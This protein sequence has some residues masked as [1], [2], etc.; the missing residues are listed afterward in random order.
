MNKNDLISTVADNSGLSK[1]DASKAVES[2][3]DAIQDFF[4]V[5]FGGSALVGTGNRVINKFHVSNAVDPA[6]PGV[7]GEHVELRGY[8]GLH[9]PLCALG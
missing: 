1:N 7:V 8:R 5:R 4:L 6:L 2:V 9:H 3:F